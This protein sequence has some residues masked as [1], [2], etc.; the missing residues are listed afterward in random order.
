MTA[1]QT[2][3]KIGNKR[4]AKISESLMKNIT[5]TDLNLSYINDQKHYTKRRK[6]SQVR[7]GGTVFKW[8]QI[9]CEGITNTSEH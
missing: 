7:N 3:H 6:G 1:K 5:L 4:A 8:N 2:E 9:G